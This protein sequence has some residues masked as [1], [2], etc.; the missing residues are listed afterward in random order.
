MHGFCTRPGSGLSVTSSLFLHCSSIAFD[1]ANAP[2]IRSDKLTSLS[3]TDAKSLALLLSCAELWGADRTS[4]LWLCSWRLQREGLGSHPA[5]Q[6]SLGTQS[7]IL[8]TMLN[9][10]DGIY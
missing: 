9:D 4:Q 3:C 6:A 2:S 7:G 8:L 1:E 5:S 10:V